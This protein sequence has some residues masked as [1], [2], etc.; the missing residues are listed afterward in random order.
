MP[1]R[2]CQPPVG[3]TMYTGIFGSVAR[4]SAEPFGAVALLSGFFAAPRNPGARIRAMRY[5]KSDNTAAV[6]REILDALSTANAGVALA[7]GA[8]RWSEALDRVFGE[9]FE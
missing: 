9:F 1:N 2:S 6:S 5:F 3:A 4:I 7:Y 8:D